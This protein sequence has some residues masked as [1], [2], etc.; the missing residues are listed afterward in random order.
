MLRPPGAFSRS[1]GAPAS[2]SVPASVG[3]LCSQGASG[4]P[5]RALT[6]ELKCEATGQGHG[7]ESEG[8]EPEFSSGSSEWTWPLGPQTPKAAAST[9]RPALH[10]D[11]L[12]PPQI[13]VMKPPLRG[14]QH[15]SVCGRGSGDH[16]GG[17]R[18]NITRV[19]VRR[20]RDP[21]TP[22]DD[23]RRTWGENR[24]YRGERPRQE[25]AP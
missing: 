12:C 23:R 1:P 10:A 14:P 11:R 8:L 6:S 4:S 16:D 25:P 13:Q 5:G 17:P 20:Y 15:V 18:S 7:P 9:Y 21:D 24:V 22:G 2:H 3:R 19:L